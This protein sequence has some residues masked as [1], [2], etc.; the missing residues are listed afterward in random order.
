[1][2]VTKRIIN[3]FEQYMKVK[4]R[5]HQLLSALYDWMNA[6]GIDTAD[7]EFADAIAVRIGNNE[8]QSSE[9]F[10][11]DLQRFIDGEQVGYG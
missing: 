3:T 1:M 11:D 10:F 6:Q 2:K 5:E 9:Q 8:F 7:N 4:D